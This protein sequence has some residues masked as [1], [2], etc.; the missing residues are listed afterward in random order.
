MELDRK[1][2]IPGMIAPGS[3]DYQQ[4]QA[5]PNGNGATFGFGNGTGQGFNAQGNSGF[6]MQ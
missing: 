6:G 3:A 1:K 5:P 2:A 4:P